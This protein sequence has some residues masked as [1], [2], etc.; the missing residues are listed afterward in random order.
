VVYLFKKRKKIGDL[1]MSDK[2]L[3]E[4]ANGLIKEVVNAELKQLGV[5]I[6]GEV[7]K[8]FEDRC[9][10][11]ED[12]NT[13]L[14]AQLEAAQAKAR[15]HVDKAAGT[16]LFKGINPTTSR[17][18]KTV[19][20]PDMM[21]QITS[22]YVKMISTPGMTMSK[23][24][25][26]S[27]MIAPEYANALMGLA[28][29][30]SV[31]LSRMRVFTPKKD[32]FYAP[33]KGTREAADAQAEGTANTGSSITAS[34][35]TFTIDTH[36]GSYIDVLVADVDDCDIDFVRDWIIPAQA[37]AIGQ[38]V[39][40]EIFNGTNSIFTSSVVDA[41]T[42]QVTFSSAANISSNNPMTYVNLLTMWNG[43]DEKRMVKPVWFGNQKAYGYVL[44]MTGGST[45]NDHP[46]YYQDLNAAPTKQL[47][48]A[49]FVFTPAIAGAPAD[50]AMFLCY[51]DPMQYGIALRGGAK[52]MVNPYILMKEGKLQF[53]S[54]LRADG[55]ILDHATAA[56]S[57]AWATMVRSD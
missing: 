27:N 48:G 31:G 9:K 14:K 57:A 3:T 34:K 45:G 2:K 50:G 22:A 15:T 7:E 24:F 4:A 38:Y 30:S 47:F 16:V 25:D 52:N 1:Q 41:T 37:E 33:V 21:E 32:I 40:D 51:G 49:E 20:A 5:D 18:F 17:N 12:A 10:A 55:N 53:I 42:T 6:Q 44:A 36:I 11:I 56:S 43:L 23:A 39:D 29:Y 35:I 28:E 26:G 8:R 13:E 19:V 46:I 54:N